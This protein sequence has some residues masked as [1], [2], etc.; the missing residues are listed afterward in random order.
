MRGSPPT[1]PRKLPELIRHGQSSLAEVHRGAGLRRGVM[2]AN[3]SL[4]IN[5]GA[6]ERIG[7]TGIGHTLTN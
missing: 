5:P 4:A 3:R 2:P 1:P 7:D 6:N